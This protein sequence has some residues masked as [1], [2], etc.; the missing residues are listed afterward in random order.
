MS[1]RKSNQFIQRKNYFWGIHRAYPPTVCSFSSFRLVC[2]EGQ[3][4]KLGD[5]SRWPS[6]CCA[7]PRAPPRT[8]TWLQ[9][10]PKS[11]RSKLTRPPQT[12]KPRAATVPGKSGQGQPVGGQH[13]G[14]TH[15]LPS[16]AAGAEPRAGQRLQKALTSS[17]EAQ[18]L[19]ARPPCKL[20]MKN[21]TPSGRC[22]SRTRWHEAWRAPGLGLAPA[23]VLSQML[24]CRP[25]PTLT[26]TLM[27]RKH[28]HHAERKGW[29]KNV[30]IRW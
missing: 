17:A 30:F 6:H 23:A 15:A 29:L 19:R 28:H 9:T 18:P 8:V 20:D 14:L 3:L 27:H 1:G 10:S 12:P 4:V 5:D 26:H 11:R 21:T 22:R 2:A 16:C 25:C 7:S 13:A 24:T